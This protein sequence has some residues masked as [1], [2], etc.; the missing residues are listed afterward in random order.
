VCY[1][2]TLGLVAL[3][4]SLEEPF[5]SLCQNQ[6]PHITVAKAQTS[7]GNAQEGPGVAAK[8]SN[9]LLERASM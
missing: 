6:H 1:D 9:D 5:A 4:A 3:R 2:A 7:S 8:Q